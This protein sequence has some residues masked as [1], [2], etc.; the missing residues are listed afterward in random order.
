MVLCWVPAGTSIHEVV[1][2]RSAER[3]ATV[4][5]VWARPGPGAA[6]SGAPEDRTS[7]MDPAGGHTTVRVRGRRVGVQRWGHAE[8]GLG[9]FR[10]GGADHQFLR[11]HVP[12]LPPAAVELLLQG[13]NLV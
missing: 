11:L 10:R 5:H 4:L 8:S 9:W 3:D 7:L 13:E 1:L 6:P 2:P 12:R